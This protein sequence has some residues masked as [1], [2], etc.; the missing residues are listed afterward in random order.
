MIREWSIEEIDAAFEAY[1]EMFHQQEAGK[2]FI[3]AVVVR[4]LMAGPLN[5][6]TRSSVERRFQNYSAIFQH[7]GLRWVHGYAPLDHVGTVVSRR[8][9]ELIN[10]AGLTA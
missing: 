5:Q 8:V 2:P 10:Q 1:L 3:K 7:R 6:R 9:N 4:N